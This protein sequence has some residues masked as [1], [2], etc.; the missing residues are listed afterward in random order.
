[1][2]N[3]LLRMF[4]AVE[5]LVTWSDTTGGTPWS[6][7]EACGKGAIQLVQVLFSDEYVLIGTSPK[8]PACGIKDIT[9][10]INKFC[11]KQVS[12]NSAA[13]EI[14]PEAFADAA[15][16]SLCGAALNPSMLLR[17][18]CDPGEFHLCCCAHKVCWFSRCIAK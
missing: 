12:S 13:C 11:Q 16:S 1:M 15:F 18:N 6:T 4:T 2:S 14:T 7:E 8:T 10:I 9:E 3:M 5:K 17:F